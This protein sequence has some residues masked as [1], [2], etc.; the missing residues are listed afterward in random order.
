MCCT[1]TCSSLQAIDH[2]GCARTSVGD[3]L[4]LALN[5][6]THDVHHGS[7]EEIHKALASI[8]SCLAGICD[9][10]HHLLEVV[11]SLQKHH[12]DNAPVS[13][14]LQPIHDPSS[15]SF[16]EK[17][18]KFNFQHPLRPAHTSSSMPLAASSAMAAC[19]PASQ[20]TPNV[21]E[22][23]IDNV[24]SDGDNEDVDSISGA[25]HKQDPVFRRVVKTFDKD[26]GHITVGYV[27]KIFIG[28]TTGNRY[29]RIQLEDW[30]KIWN[31]HK[32][33][34]P[35]HAVMCHD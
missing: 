30:C 8:S 25:A 17:M 29:Y 13:G 24:S 21:A 23:N 16:V 31:N 22:S 6:G 15:M 27:Q 2:C 5:N 26:A 12:D 1:S 32:V 9:A 19:S 14:P 18:S 20:H 7:I 28:R 4:L 34:D 35:D 10:Q 11:T 3:A 33:N